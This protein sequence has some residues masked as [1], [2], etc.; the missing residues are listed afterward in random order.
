[1]NKCENC[2]KYFSCN[3][4]GDSSSVEDKDSCEFDS[5]L[6]FYNTEELDDRFWE[7]MSYRKYRGTIL[8]Y[9]F[10]EYNNGMWN[11]E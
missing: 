10:D 1:M 11:W 9:N 4:N 8:D 5:T 2:P 6:A 3:V 7:E